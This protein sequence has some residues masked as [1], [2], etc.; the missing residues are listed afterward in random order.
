MSAYLE[1][2]TVPGQT[3]NLTVIRDNETISVPLEL[4]SRPNST[5]IT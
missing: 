2:Y 3:V 4:G 1:E 5:N